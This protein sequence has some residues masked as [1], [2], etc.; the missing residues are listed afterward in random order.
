MRGRFGPIGKHRSHAVAIGPIG[1]ARDRWGTVGRLPG[2]APNP[3]APSPHGPPPSRFPFPPS[4]LSLL[5]PGI[6]PP[7]N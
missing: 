1:A 6:A 7:G 2:G 3:R 4:F 5:L